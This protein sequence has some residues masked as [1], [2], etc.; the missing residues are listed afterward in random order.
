MIVI[1]PQQ[2]LPPGPG[3]KLVI[4]QGYLSADG[5]HRGSSDFEAPIGDIQEFKIETPG[6]PTCSIGRPAWS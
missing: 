3:W 2:P 4:A 6:S 5:R 1:E